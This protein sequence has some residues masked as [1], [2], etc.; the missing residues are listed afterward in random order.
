[1]DK[2]NRVWDCTHPDLS[3]LHCLKGTDRMV[4][5]VNA[6]GKA[7]KGVSLLHVDPWGYIVLIPVGHDPFGGGRISD[8]LPTEYLHYYS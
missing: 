8:T 6:Q 7:V 3:F 4:L 2:S 1:M 5:F